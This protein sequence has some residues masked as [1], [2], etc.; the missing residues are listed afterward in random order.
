MKVN[1]EVIKGIQKENDG[2][3]T[4]IKFIY[5]TYHIKSKIEIH[6]FG[7]KIGYKVFRL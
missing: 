5:G 7:T 4:Y 2:V 3:L 6:M 1:H